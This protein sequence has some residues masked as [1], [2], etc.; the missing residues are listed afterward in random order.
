MATKM[1]TITGTP[2]AIANTL[3]FC[4]VG[5]FNSLDVVVAFPLDVLATD[6]LVEDE[7][8]V[9]VVIHALFPRQ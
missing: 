2:M 6:P 1:I 5:V 4:G 8:E 3:F 7:L 9:I